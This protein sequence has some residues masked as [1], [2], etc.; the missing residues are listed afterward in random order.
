VVPFAI[1]ESTYTGLAWATVLSVIGLFVVGVVKAYVARGS[2]LK[3][4]LENLTVAAVGGVLAW[5]I[6]Q[7]FNTT[8]T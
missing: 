1:A 8:V 4:G 3:S 7:A 5:G 2:W 6:G